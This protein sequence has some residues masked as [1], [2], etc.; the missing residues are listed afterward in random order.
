[1]SGIQI[2]LQLFACFALSFLATSVGIVVIPDSPGGMEDPP[3]L[4]R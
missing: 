4:C 2:V 1:V 3:D